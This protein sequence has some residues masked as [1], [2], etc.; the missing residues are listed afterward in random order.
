MK[1]KGGEVSPPLSF[2][3]K[4]TMKFLK[5]LYLEIHILNIFGV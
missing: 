4:Y 1:E 2:C 5:N 3:C